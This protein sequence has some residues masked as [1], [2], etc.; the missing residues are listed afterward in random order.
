MHDS[1]EVGDHQMTYDELNTDANR[2]AHA[3]LDEQEE[4]KETVALILKQGPKAI[5][6][7]H[8]S[9]QTFRTGKGGGILEAIFLSFL[10]YQK[11]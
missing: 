7:M 4:S 3:L 6:S 10:V 8:K 11:K 9:K 1:P 5:V 2:L